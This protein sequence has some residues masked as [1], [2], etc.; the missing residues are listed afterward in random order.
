MHKKGGTHM[1]R[2][3]F[4]AILLAFM[5]SASAAQAMVVKYCD[6]SCPGARLEW[7]GVKVVFATGRELNRTWNT[8]E[9]SDMENYAIIF[10]PEQSGRFLV[11]IE[12]M[13][14][15]PVANFEISEMSI[16]GRD[17]IA[18]KDIKG[19]DVLIKLTR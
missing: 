5:L 11:K 8:R 2:I 19:V 4:L 9:Y 17:R 3:V 18:A 1:K 12:S 16:S 14:L 6:I 10:N 13:N 15:G 7:Q